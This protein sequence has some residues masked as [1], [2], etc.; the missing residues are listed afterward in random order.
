NQGESLDDQVTYMKLFEELQ[1][2]LNPYYFKENTSAKEMDE[3]KVAAFVARTRDY[4][5]G[6]TIKSWPGR[7]QKWLKGRIKPLHPVEGTNLCWID[8]SNIVHIGADRQFDDQY[9]LTVTTQNGQSYRV[10]DVLLPGRLLDAAHE[11]LFRALDSSTGG[12]F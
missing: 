4:K 1:Y 5:H 2:N 10:N 3:D 11:A 7:P 8:T 6:I 9:Y 12:N